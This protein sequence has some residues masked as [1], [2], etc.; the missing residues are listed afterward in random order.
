MG[1]AHLAREER[2]Y[3]CQAVP[4]P[5]F[6]AGREALGVGVSW[7]AAHSLPFSLYSQCS[8]YQPFTSLWEPPEQSAMMLSTISRPQCGQG[9][10][11][12]L[13]SLRLLI[14]SPFW[15]RKTDIPEVC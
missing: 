11:G 3:I 8:Q 1:Y 10:S 4:L 5:V 13:A 2:Y 15:F 12:S 7:E 9:C 6:F 14:S